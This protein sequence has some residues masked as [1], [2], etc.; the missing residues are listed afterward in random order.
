MTLKAGQ[1]KYIGTTSLNIPFSTDPFPLGLHALPP[2]LLDRTCTQAGPASSLE[3]RV[4]QHAFTHASLINE[5]GAA[6]TNSLRPHA[7]GQP[8]RQASALTH[9]RGHASPQI[10]NSE[11]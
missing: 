2:G 4:A 11:Q 7:L 3:R 10:V 9:E 6:S 1:Y 5:N 8:V